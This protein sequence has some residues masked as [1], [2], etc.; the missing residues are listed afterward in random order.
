MT[1]IKVE[2]AKVDGC[3]IVTPC[4][5]LAELAI[6]VD[7]TLVAMENDSGFDKE[8][9]KGLFLKALNDL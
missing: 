3:I 1:I 9:F 2:N 6:A 4:E 5:V 7:W 8:L